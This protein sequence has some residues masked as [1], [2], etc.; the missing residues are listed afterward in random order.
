MVEMTCDLAPDQTLKSPIISTKI[1]KQQNNYEN[2]EHFFEGAEKL[3]EIW[4]FS[5]EK[6]ASLRKIPKN[7]LDKLM[8]IAGCKILQVL[9]SEQ[10]DSYLLR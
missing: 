4:F 3:L 10:I 9:K 2:S 5:K 8:D 6:N 1:E 7:E